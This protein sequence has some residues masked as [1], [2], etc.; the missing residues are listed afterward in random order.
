VEGNA[1]GAQ[2]DVNV[3]PSTLTK[4]TDVLTVGGAAAYGADAIAGVVNFILKDDF[5]G[6]TLRSLAGISGRGDSG[7]YQFAATYGVN[8]AEGRGNIALS[9]EYS[10]NDGLQA[11]ARDFRLARPNSYT[12][13]FNGS[14]R[15]PAFV[16]AIIN[17]AESNNGAFLSNSTDGIAATLFGAGFVNQTL[18]FNGTVF[19]PLTTPYSSLTAYTPITNAAGTITS[20]F[21][22]FRNGLAPNGITA[23]GTTAAGSATSF[24]LR[25]VGYFA[26]SGQVISGAPGVGYAGTAIV[27]GSTYTLAANGLN[28]ATSS[29]LPITTFAPTALPTGVTAAQVFT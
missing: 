18:S 8:F 6:L 16:P 22:S 27:N 13:P 4:R 3:I 17:V 25:N 11:D 14:T 29:P 2:V 12:N 24:T 1:T 21:I 23:P 19:N 5:E 26:N 15:N 7:Q 10:R 20:N 9:A 28:G